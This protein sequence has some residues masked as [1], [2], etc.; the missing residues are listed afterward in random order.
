MTVN[1]Q[2]YKL[3][4][5]QQ[6]QMAKD[7]PK[8]SGLNLQDY[9][10]GKEE[11]EAGGLLS[12]LVA[13]EKKKD[14]FSRGAVKGLGS[15]VSGASALGERMIRGA[16]RLVTPKRFEES[17]GFAEPEEGELL[18][19]QLQD[20]LKPT[21]EAEKAGFM[22]E[23][24]A[25]FFVPGGAPLKAAR[26]ISGAGRLSKLGRVGARVGTEMLVAGGQEAM[27]RG[28]IDD[29]VVTTSL[30]GGATSFVA[31]GG[32]VTTRVA[33]R[34][35]D[36]LIKPVKRSVS[37]GKNPGVGIVRE[38]IVARSFDD[39]E[40]KVF[41]ARHQV[42]IQIGQAIKTAQKKFQG[43]KTEGL[44]INVSNVFEEINKQLLEAQKAPRTNKELIRRLRSAK[45]DIAEFFG[46][47][48]GKNS[49]E[50]ILNGPVLGKM[51]NLSASAAFELKTV[52]SN[53]TKFTDSP[54][55][56]DKINPAL[57]STYNIVKRKLSQA[58]PELVELNERY[59]N[60]TGANIAI[61][62]RKD[63]VRRQNI[64]F[65]GFGPGMA[66]MFGGLYTAVQSGG[67]A[68]KTA[69]AGLSAAAIVRIASSIPAK[70]S[71]AYII[72]KIGKEGRRSFEQ[73]SQAF[74]EALQQ[75]F[76]TDSLD[77]ISNLIPKDEE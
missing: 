9:Q 19:D 58:I 45:N 52:I 64:L 32:S 65:Q 4:P 16:G 24:I 34:I 5:G 75:I 31:S 77:E 18:G 25:E 61:K 37:Y 17:L 55:D 36:S 47:K 21:N 67:N 53:M 30:L 3:S 29:A 51:R 62:N 63:I 23:Q 39:L 50:P 33:G 68:G 7:P 10:Q 2:N 48:M 1:L 54:L 12:R 13:L 11:E 41:R 76:G 27:Q 35:I 8:S 40:D 15:T 28:E 74:R 6:N 44:T 56:D 59:A 70:T 60:L 46:A 38:G 69:I 71:L 22:T 72:G 26:L 14:D 42:G 43:Q 57:R 49:G 20:K 73:G 66:A